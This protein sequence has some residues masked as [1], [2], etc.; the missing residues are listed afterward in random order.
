MINLFKNKDGAVAL[1]AVLMV[2]AI[3]IIVVLGMSD[4]QLSGSKKYFNNYAEKTIYYL[5]EACLEEAIIRIERDTSYPGGLVT[6][7]SDSSCNISISGT[8]F[9]NLNL[10]VEYLNYSQ[11][12]L[13]NISVTQNGQANNVALLNWSKVN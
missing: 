4:S 11:N 1:M 12:Y 10:T 3:L 5:A 13:G 9:K 2:S 7:S 8:S 6:L